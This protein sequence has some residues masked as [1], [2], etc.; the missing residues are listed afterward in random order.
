MRHPHAAS[1]HHGDQSL[2]T[3]TEPRAAWA[4]YYRRTG[5]AQT[6]G[7]FHPV[8]GRGQTHSASSSS[9]IQRN[10]DALRGWNTI[11]KLE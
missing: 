6:P 1:T 9:G 11:G 10:S 2:A 8:A 4:E 5:V 3:E 7:S